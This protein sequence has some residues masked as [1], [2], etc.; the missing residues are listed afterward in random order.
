MPEDVMKRRVL[1]GVMGCDAV[2]GAALSMIARAIRARLRFADAT[3]HE[4]GSRGDSR[5]APT[6]DWTEAVFRGMAV[7]VVTDT[8]YHENGG[9]GDSRIAPTG[10]WTGVIFRGMAVAVPILT[11]PTA[12]AGD[13]FLPSQE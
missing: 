1:V 3:Y 13:G 6:G 4:N 8:T 11:C 10:D 5:I 7:A 2:L 12:T 9:R